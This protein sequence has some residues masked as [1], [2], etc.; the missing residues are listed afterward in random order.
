MPLA[1]DRYL[2]VPFVEF[3]ANSFL[4]VRGR[5]EQ[6]EDEIV[7]L[8]VSGKTALVLAGSRGL[9][10]ATAT[11]LAF[12][13]ARVFIVSRSE[14]AIQKA[15]KE[16][17]RQV[18]GAKVVPLVGDVSCAED[19]TR[20]YRYI[21]SESDGV[22]ILVNNCGGPSPG[23]FLELKD[24]EVWKQA[25]ELTLMS[26]VRSIRH[27]LSPMKKNG[28]GRI[29]NITSSSMKQPIPNLV[30]SNVFRAGVASLTKSI[31]LEVAASGILVNAVGPGRIATERVAS[32]DLASAKASG[33]SL[34]E[35]ELQSAT[36]I[37]IG[38]Y[39][40]PQEFAKVVAFLA[41]G[42]NGYMTGQSLLVDG[43]LVS[44]M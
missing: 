13:G 33:L 19:L 21:E 30:L 22:D 12:H 41:S 20:I 15:A 17:V 25:Y 14:E 16:L 28:W 1:R 11:E 2:P 6:W 8:M 35:V 24:D 34:A 44:A 23:T 4:L 37:P 42:A 36:R 31:A 32:L 3:L 9:G 39:G 40:T 10:F 18:P 5:C 26:A 29:V 43:G 27:A 7:D 38:R